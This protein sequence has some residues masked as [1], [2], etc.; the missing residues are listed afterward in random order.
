MLEMDVLYYLDYQCVTGKLFLRTQK[1]NHFGP[2]SK[3]YLHCKC[4]TFHCKTNAFNL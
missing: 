1:N 4:N 3:A 2:E